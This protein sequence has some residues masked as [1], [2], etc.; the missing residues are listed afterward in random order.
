MLLLETEQLFMEGES[1]NLLDLWVEDQ[2]L[3]GEILQR[4]GRGGLLPHLTEQQL[5]DD[6]K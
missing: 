5:I 6:N 2:I 1:F 3:L 4:N